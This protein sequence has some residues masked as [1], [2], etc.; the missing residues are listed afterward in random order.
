MT[1]TLA[2]VGSWTSLIWHRVN[3]MKHSYLLFRRFLDI[4]IWP[5]ARCLDNG[6]SCLSL[7]KNSAKAAKNRQQPLYIVSNPASVIQSHVIHIIENMLISKLRNKWQNI[8]YVYLFVEPNRPV[9]EHEHFG[10]VWY[11]HRPYRCAGS[12]F[13]WNAGKYLRDEILL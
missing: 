2:L 1:S 10:E 5:D 12:S 13:L 4:N 7:N 6:I 11:L 9:F 3:R 8:W